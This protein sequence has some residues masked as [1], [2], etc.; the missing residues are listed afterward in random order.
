MSDAEILASF[1]PGFLAA[2][3]AVLVEG[4]R[5]KGCEPWESGGNQ[6]FKDHLTHLAG[7]ADRAWCDADEYGPQRVDPEDITHAAAR[8]ALAWA[9]RVK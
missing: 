4:A 5:V 2:V 9:T 3:A 7:H 6:S 8:C 1:P